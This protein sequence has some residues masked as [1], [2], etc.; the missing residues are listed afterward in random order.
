MEMAGSG[1]DEAGSDSVVF[2]C[3]KV[4]GQLCGVFF[5]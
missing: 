2:L 4:A 1:P 3:K 5:N